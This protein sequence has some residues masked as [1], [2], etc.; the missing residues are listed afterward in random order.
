MVDKKDNKARIQF[1]I[2]LHKLLE[3]AENEGNDGII[4][5][6][7]DGLS[8]TVYKPIEFAEK[9]MPRYF[10]QTRY[11]SFQRQVRALLSTKHSNMAGLTVQR[12]SFSGNGLVFLRFTIFLLL[13]TAILFY[14]VV[15]LQ[16]YQR[17]R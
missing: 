7:H 14:A 13:N 12:G 9:I 6:Q 4:G 15:R 1:P 5:W 11:R 3:D 17:E 2:K 10:G 16:V 8:F